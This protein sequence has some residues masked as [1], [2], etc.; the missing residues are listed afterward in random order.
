MPGKLGTKK[1]SLRDADSH[2]VSDESEG[3]KN[4]KNMVRAEMQELEHDNPDEEFIPND[5]VHGSKVRQIKQDAEEVIIDELL[6]GVPQDQGFYLKLYKELGPNKYQLKQRIDN[7]FDWADLEWEVT[8]IVRQQT[9]KSP[10]RWGSGSYK[11]IV[12]KEGGIRTREFKPVFLDIDAEEPENSVSGVSGVPVDPTVSMENQLS[13]FA[14]MMN[15]LKGIMPPGQD[16][17]QTQEILAKAFKSGVDANPPKDSGPDPNAMQNNMMA[18]MFSGM[19]T[20]L[21]E[22]IKSNNN[23]NRGDAGTSPMEILAQAQNNFQNMMAQVLAKQNTN[24]D[25]Y[26]TGFS[27]AMELMKQMNLQNQLKPNT[28]IKPPSMFD[29]IKQLKEIGLWKTPAEDGGGGT[30]KQISDLKN[31]LSVVKDILPSSDSANLSFGER[32]LDRLIPYVPDAISKVSEVVN[33]V[34]ELNK[35]KL[36][37]V[38]R[39]QAVSYG[40]EDV[41]QTADMMDNYE[42]SFGAGEDGAPP[43]FDP[44][45]A[46]NEGLSQGPFVSAEPNEQRPESPSALPKP[47]PRLQSRPESKLASKPITEPRSESGFAEQVNPLENPGGLSDSGDSS[48]FDTEFSDEEKK[49]MMAVRSGFQSVYNLIMGHVTTENPE[50]TSNRCQAILDI[51]NPMLIQVNVDFIQGVGTD[52]IGR[53]QVLEMMQQSGGKAFRS[54]GFLAKFG[55]F[56]PKFDMYVKAIYSELSNYIPVKCDKVECGAEF[57]V[58]PIDFNAVDGDNVCGA[59]TADG[60]YC[61]GILKPITH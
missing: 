15:A 52:G 12:W 51:I 39:Q 44:Y 36:A 7:F 21:A 9:K 11:L 43:S 38:P 20:I 45:G 19:F 37:R 30:I 3:L 24:P 32:L 49:S 35:A 28:G 10:S 59:Q 57:D 46:E 31:L 53:D 26:Q 34:I 27:Q 4:I 8:K 6:A 14:S 50:I 23:G 13:S 2:G 42:R 29:T 1:A 5:A 18:P 55:Q 47:E 60:G 40:N 58:N 22:M 16:P 33:N 61:T 54:P 17:A 25:Q 56:Y 48:N 41:E